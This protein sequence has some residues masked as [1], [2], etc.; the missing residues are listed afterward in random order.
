MTNSDWCGIWEKKKKL[1]EARNLSIRSSNLQTLGTRL[2]KLISI[3]GL[4]ANGGSK[5]EQV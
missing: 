1:D 3:T 4:S 2:R 5:H